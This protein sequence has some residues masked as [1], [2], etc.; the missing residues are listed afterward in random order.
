MYLLRI[1]F[2]QSYRSK[3]RLFT[4]STSGGSGEDN[5]LGPNNYNNQLQSS[6][7]LNQLSPASSGSTLMPTSSST[8]QP[9]PCGPLPSSSPF[10]VIG[11]TNVG[12][13]GASVYGSHSSAGLTTSA[14]LSNSTSVATIASKGK[15]P[16]RWSG[17]WGLSAK[18]HYTSTYCYMNRFS[19][20][21]LSYVLLRNTLFKTIP[22][23]VAGQ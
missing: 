10:G 1:Y 17:L 19:L 22:H 20:N 5:T 18:V 6:S 2:S 21:V 9:S 8:L 4:S 3:S 13:M 11:S 7:Y 16:N 12:T 14:S 15:H 23:Y